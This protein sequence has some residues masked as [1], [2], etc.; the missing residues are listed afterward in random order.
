MVPSSTY[1]MHKVGLQMLGCPHLQL[2]QGAGH[3]HS[4]A[5][6]SFR[7]L[8]LPVGESRMLQP[9]GI[10]GGI[11]LLPY[12]KHGIVQCMGRGKGPSVC[13]TSSCCR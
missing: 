4:L 3:E 1:L 6:G 11:P 5:Q 2:C 7:Q 8:P 9:L 13:G 12:L 10:A